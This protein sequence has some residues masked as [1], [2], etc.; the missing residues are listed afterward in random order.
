MQEMRIIFQVR[1]TVRFSLPV[2]RKQP[3]ANC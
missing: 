1:P 2:I 3:W